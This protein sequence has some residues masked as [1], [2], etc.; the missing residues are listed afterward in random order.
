MVFVLELLS[1]RMSRRTGVDGCV[2]MT[3]V[4]FLVALAAIL[5]L[6]ST[7]VTFSLESSDPLYNRA[8]NWKTT[9]TIGIVLIVSL[10]SLACFLFSDQGR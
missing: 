4:S 5:V 8:E 9:L 2:I 1:N 10:P 7:A 6:N 3:V